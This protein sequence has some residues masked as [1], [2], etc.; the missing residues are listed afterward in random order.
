MYFYF[1]QQILAAQMEKDGRIIDEI[2]PNLETIQEGW[3]GIETR[4]EEA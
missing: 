2:L 3:A 4:D 1:Y